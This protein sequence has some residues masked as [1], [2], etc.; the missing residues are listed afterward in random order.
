MEE[1]DTVKVEIERLVPDEGMDLSDA[2]TF[3]D[4]DELVSERHGR[5]FFCRKGNPCRFHLKLELPSTAL[6]R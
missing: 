6:P 1:G 5:C 2:P 4:P 3:E